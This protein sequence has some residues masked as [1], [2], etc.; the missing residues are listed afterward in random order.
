MCTDLRAS[1]T[2]TVEYT[3]A[4]FKDH[5]GD[6]RDK[7][8]VFLSARCAKCPITGA[9]PKH[10]Q[11]TLKGC[12]EIQT[13][14][15]YWIDQLPP[16]A[17]FKLKVQITALTCR[18]ETWQQILTKNNTMTGARHSCDVTR[19]LIIRTTSWHLPLHILRLERK[20]KVVVHWDIVGILHGILLY[21]TFCTLDIAL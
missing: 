3:A 15:N 20:E 7:C 17:S 10:P 11:L 8:P 14:L 18:S 9:V 19:L 12:V 4:G 1:C 16:A 5:G 13:Q 6:M 2:A 21:G